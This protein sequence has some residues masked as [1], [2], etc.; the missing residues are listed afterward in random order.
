MWKRLKYNIYNFELSWGEPVFQCFSSHFLF[1]QAKLLDHVEDPAR[2]ARNNLHTRFKGVDV[3]GYALATNANMHL[4]IQVVTLVAV[5][6]ETKEKIDQHWSTMTKP[7]KSHMHSRHWMRLL[8][9][10]IA[11]LKLETV[12]YI[13]MFLWFFMAYLLINWSTSRHHHYEHG[14]IGWNWCHPAINMLTRFTHTAFRIQFRPQKPKARQTF[15]LCSASSR[16]GDKNRACRGWNAGWLIWTQVQMSHD[17][18]KEW[19]RSQTSKIWSLVANQIDIVLV[20]LISSIQNQWHDMDHPSKPQ[21]DFFP[22]LLPQPNFPWSSCP[23][24]AHES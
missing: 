15:W 16:V 24:G 1:L 2:G 14:E 17:I 22:Q 3:I 11:P 8:T 12:K 9:R 21:Q 19:P 20:V 7:S 4:D 13:Q 10:E 5:L 18:S 23:P 6:D